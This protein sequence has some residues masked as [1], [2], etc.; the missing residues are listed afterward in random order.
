MATGAVLTGG[1]GIVAGLAAYKAL[2]SVAR[3]FEDLDETEQRIVQYCWMLI[4]MIDDYLEREGADFS[5]DNADML[6]NDTLLPLHTLL[7]ENCEAICANL[8]WKNAAAYRQHVLRDFGPAIIDPFSSFTASSLAKK[9]LHYDYVIGGVLYALLTR[10]AVDD[11]LEARL[12][13]DALR[14]SDSALANASEAELSSYLDDYD[15]EQLKGI[16]NNVKGIYHELLWVEQFNASHEDTRAELFD[17][18]NHAGSD[19]RV[20]DIE[21]GDVV[22]EY[23]L[24]ATDNIAYLNEHH[25]KYP[26]IRV[27]VTDEAAGQIEGA[28]ASGNTNAR[29]TD[30]VETNLEALDDNTLEDRVL[31]GAGLAAAISTGQELLEML[32]GDREFPEAVTEVVKKTGTAG[33]ATALAAYL[34]S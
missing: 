16:A 1:V 5:A 15:P 21:S 2:G 19:V 12:V 7:N 3:N 25:V 10:S 20:V 24:K 18:T 26:G 30:D 14:R 4:A 27:I 13:L 22:A 8:D 11:S 29:L 31:E 33:A 6:L 32:R 28:Q 23:Q 34:F 17:T 9:A